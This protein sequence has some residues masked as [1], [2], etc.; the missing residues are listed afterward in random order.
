MLRVLPS[1]PFAG[2]V[3]A[4]TLG[5]YP[6]AIVLALAAAA[7]IIMIICLPDPPALS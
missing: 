6:L 2:A 3:L 4:F 1:V 7:V 5:Y